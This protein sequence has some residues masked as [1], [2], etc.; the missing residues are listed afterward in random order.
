MTS[1]KDKAEEGVIENTDETEIK[2]T[3]ARSEFAKKVEA[4]FTPE[5]WA[6]ALAATREADDTPPH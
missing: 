3:P 2:S 4:A 1:E 6:R 5:A